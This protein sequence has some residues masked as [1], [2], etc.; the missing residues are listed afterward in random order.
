MGATSP[1]G[2]SF[3][4][5]Y[6]GDRRDRPPQNRNQRNGRNKATPLRA[7]SESAPLQIHHFRGFAPRRTAPDHVGPTPDHQMPRRDHTGS[8]SPMYRDVGAADEIYAQGP[9]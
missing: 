9:W 7:H 1:T 6:P 3:R 8:P 2:I 5:R 4:H